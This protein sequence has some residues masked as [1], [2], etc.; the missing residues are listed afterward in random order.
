MSK[1]AN[2]RV[3]P[4]EPADEHDRKLLADVERHGW[5]VIGVMEDRE[6]PAFAYSIGLYHTF[7]HP[8]LIIFGLPVRVMHQIIN[9]VG[10]EIR[11][12]ERFEHLAEYDD[13][14]EGYRVAFRTLAGRHYREYLGFARWFYRGDDF[15]ALQCVWPDARYRYP[16]HPEAEPAFIERQP[17]LS[18]DTSWPFHEGKNRAVFTTRPVLQG[19]HPI[20]LVTHDRNGDWQ[21]LCGTTNRSEDGQVVSLAAIL[22]RDPT[23]AEVADLPEGSQAQREQKGAPWKREP[24]KI[25]N[26]RR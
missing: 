9:L 1:K 22:E 2:G 8:E 24:D 4:P 14:L 17:L 7:G 16:W 19:G 23:V 25:H 11:S 15:P 12:G 18:D 3:G 10:E 13:I 20:L 21:F 26:V 5:H 6:G